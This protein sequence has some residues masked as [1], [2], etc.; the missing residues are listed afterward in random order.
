M[1]KEDPNQPGNI[2][3]Y[4]YIY[5][6]LM[7]L[8]RNEKKGGVRFK[9]F[10]DL[11]GE[12]FSLNNMHDIR[13]RG[14]GGKHRQRV[15]QGQGPPT[16]FSNKVIKPLRGGGGVTALTGGIFTDT[17][18]Q[19]PLPKCKI[20]KIT[21]EDIDSQ[22]LPHK[23][24]FNNGY[25]N[26]GSQGAGSQRGS[27]EMGE[28][29]VSGRGGS[30]KDVAGN[31]QKFD[32]IISE[33][34]IGN[35]RYR[36]GKGGHQC[37]KFVPGEEITEMEVRKQIFEEVLQTNEELDRGESSE[38]EEEEDMGGP[39]YGNPFKKQKQQSPSRNREGDD[40]G[41]GMRFNKGVAKTINLLGGIK[42]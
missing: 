16:F 6:A 34:P 25:N 26:N 32:N 40:V 37:S 41:V 2:Y 7:F 36:K 24:L 8:Q 31:I 17:P 35:N 3:I 33:R 39:D 38:E 27:Q 20:S 10:D 29:D 13:R 15:G 42:Y 23:L 30:H 14:A 21:G 28:R 22:G 4:I 11:I 5:I 9:R 12:R 18:N 1:K 19:T